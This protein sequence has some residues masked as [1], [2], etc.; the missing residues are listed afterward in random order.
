V[1]LILGV[2]DPFSGRL[3]VHDGLPQSWDVL[4]VTKNPSCAVC[5]EHPTVTRLVEP[6]AFCQG[7]PAVGAAMAARSVPAA[8]DPTVRAAAGGPGP[9]ISVLELADLLAGKGGQP[10]VLLV[11]VRGAVER[12]TS[13]IPGAQ[14]VDL[15]DLRSGAAVRLI[16]FDRPVVILARAG[17]RCQEAARILTEA[18]HPDVRSLAGGVLAWVRDVDPARPSPGTERL[19]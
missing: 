17:V 13:V 16:P 5:G 6:E 15:D 9:Q 7:T 8:A 18:G 1:K 4:S 10:G 19:G 3:M 12:T 2:A 11:D 14:G